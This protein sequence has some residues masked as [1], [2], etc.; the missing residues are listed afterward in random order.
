MRSVT[1]ALVL[2][3]A[4]LTAGPARAADKIRWT[5]SDF[6]PA[7]IVHGEHAGTGIFDIETRYLTGRLGEFAHVMLNVAN[8]RAWAMLPDQDGIC[9]AGALE[10]PERR[11]IAA[12]SRV[13]LAVLPPGLLIRK[14][15][16]GRF[17]RFRNEAGEID[18]ALLAADGSLR[19]AHTAARPMG[20]AIERF[21][22]RQKLTSLP[23][24]HQALE[25]LANGRL[26]YSFGYANE[27]SYYR[28]THPDA[29]ELT[30]LRVAGQP[31][32]IYTHIACSNRPI[33]R[34][35]IA[36]IDEILG[37]HGES[38]YFQETGRWYDAD[39]F[40]DLS[41]MAKWP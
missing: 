11:R 21:I 39:D 22:E 40:R 28:A 34:R 33:G 38:P 19:A 27:A 36:R 5:S 4:V 30:P 15:E 8:S 20:T 12:F 26:D 13:T 14:S 18:L 24:S 41:A 9:I 25:M 17:A 6:P 1:I 3:F 2:A 23:A 32:I 7:F 31:P 35:V 29:P 10:T 16:A 37:P